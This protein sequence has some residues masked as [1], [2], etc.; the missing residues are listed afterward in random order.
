MADPVRD[1]LLTTSGELAV[2]NGDFGLAAGRPAVIQGI[3]TY[4]QMVIADSFLDESQ[5]I[6]YPN[7][8]FDKQADPLVVRAVIGDQIARVP[9]VTAVVGADL[10]FDDPSDPR[11][12]S[13]A[14]EVADVYSTQP[15]IGTVATP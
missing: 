7:D 10:V 12:A 8:V 13:I 11:N 6:D 4:V 3:Q 1:L 14:Y 2:V 5:G 9:D 15:L